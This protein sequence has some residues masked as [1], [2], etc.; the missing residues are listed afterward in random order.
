MHFTA[1]P[2]DDPINKEMAIKIVLKL[3]SLMFEINK[4]TQNFGRMVFDLMKLG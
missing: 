3:F 1:I 4:Q 2:G